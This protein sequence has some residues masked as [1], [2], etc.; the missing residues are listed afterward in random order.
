MRFPTRARGC[1]RMVCVYRKAAAR[2]IGNGRIILRRNSLLFLGR[3]TIRR[4]L[5]TKR[6]S[7]TIGF[8]I[9]PRFFGATFSVVKTR[10]GRL[11][12]FL[13]KTLYKESRRASCLCFRITSVLPIRGL[14]RGVI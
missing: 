12:S 10:R 13:I 9:L 11:G 2:V 4:V 14:V 1:V 5:P 6:C 7:V 8:V 3:G